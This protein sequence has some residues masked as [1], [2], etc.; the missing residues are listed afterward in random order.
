MLHG[1][2]VGKLEGR[3]RNPVYALAFS[4]DAKLVVAGGMEG[5]LM[6]WDRETRRVLTNF[7]AQANFTVGLAFS[8]DGHMLASS[9]GGDDIIRVWSVSDWRNIAQL[10]GHHNGRLGPHFRPGRAD[11]HLAPVEIIRSSS[12]GFG[13]PLIIASSCPRNRLV[14]FTA[15]G[16]EVRHFGQRRHAAAMEPAIPAPDNASAAPGN[17]QSGQ[18]RRRFRRRTSS[19]HRL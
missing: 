9:G 12:G 19:R 15:G 13:R 6:V 18:N 7:Q 10:K 5:E 11:A 2:R 3:L 8:G 17:E 14:D 4:P 16:K 1:D